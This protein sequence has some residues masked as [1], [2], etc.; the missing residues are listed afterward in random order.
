MDT[1]AGAPKGI[2][3]AGGLASRFRPVSLSVTKQLLPVYDKPAIYYPLTT[4]LLA[5]L[6]DILVI[7]SENDLP[8]IQKLL[9]NGNQWGISIEYS[10]QKEPIGIAHAFVLADKFLDQKSS[11][12]ILGDNLFHGTGLGRQLTNFRTDFGA[13]VTSCWVKDPN[14]FGVI[15]FDRGGNITSIEEKPRLPK[16]NWVIPGLYAF[17]GT[18]TERV[19][20]LQPSP[21]GELEIIDLLKSYLCESNLDVRLLPRGTTWLDLGTPDSLLEASQYIKLLQNRQGVLIGSPDE[22]AWNLNL[23]DDSEFEKLIELSKNSIYGEALRQILISGKKV[24]GSYEE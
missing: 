16:T 15:E 18:V 7:S 10:I 6:R 22:A 17:D 4:L 8:S 1:T 13:I 2:I 9:K 11:I 3:L 20:K 5:G 21:R 24:P 12:L 19:K 23:I 14:H